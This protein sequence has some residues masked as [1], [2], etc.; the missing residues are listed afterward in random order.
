MAKKTMAKKTMAQKT[1]PEKQRQKN[2][3]AKQTLDK[4]TVQMTEKKQVQQ[5]YQK[6]LHI[7]SRGR[8][9]NNKKKT[10]ASLF[11]YMQAENSEMLVFQFFFPAVV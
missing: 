2:T 9:K 8:C 10:N 6:I 7:Q 1:K 11:V 4:N 3:K 5:K